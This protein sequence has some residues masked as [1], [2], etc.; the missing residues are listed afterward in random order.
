MCID[1]RAVHVSE[2]TYLL[3]K[4]FVSH[5]NR[6]GLLLDKQ[7]QSAPGIHDNERKINDEFLA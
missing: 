2:P 3:K 5:Q 6:M 1:S 7:E 4:H